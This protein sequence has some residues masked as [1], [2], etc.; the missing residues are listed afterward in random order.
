MAYVDE[1]TALP[2]RRSLNEELLNLGKK[3]AIAMIDV[4]NFKKF[5]DQYGHKAGDQVLKK[6][7]SKLKSMT[8]G[9]KVFRYGG[10]E[11]TA[12]FP[13]KGLEEALPHLEVYRRLIRYD[14]FVI[15]GKDRQKKSAEN[16]SK[17]GSQ[18]QK[19]VTVTVSIGVAASGK[20]SAAPEEVLK[21]ADRALYKAK[22]AGKNRVAS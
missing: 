9:A 16:R 2:G 5:N 14:P 17:N 15:R 13:G 1:L 21:E 3:Y 12:V 8:G 4:D 10:E 18:N 7:A 6:I 20:E 11:F 22:R 19:R